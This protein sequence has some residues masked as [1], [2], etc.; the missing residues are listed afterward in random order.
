MAEVYSFN[1]FFLAL[2]V[3]WILSY[4]RDKKNWQLCLASLTTGLSLSN[5]YPL[6]ILSGL[7]LIFLLD[8]RD[9]R[10]SDFLKGFGLVLL[11]LSPYLY[12]F[13]QA[14]NPDL[15]YNF[16]KVSDAAV[17]TDRDTGKSRGFGFV[18]MADRK[19]AA[20]AIDEM[21]GAELDGR[22]IVVNMATERR[23]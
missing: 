4:N 16:G 8:R 15:D 19:D 21:N 3:Y 10:R 6:T 14:H 9:L 22:A 1:A 18:T 12:L 5:H 17:V 20:K 13:I 23:R 11:G 7:G 2:I